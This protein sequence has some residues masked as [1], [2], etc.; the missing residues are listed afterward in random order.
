MRVQ[1][2]IGRWGER[3]VIE[4][5][6]SAMLAIIEMRRSTAEIGLLPWRLRQG[7]RN[8]NVGSWD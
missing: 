1:R 6:H 5:G 4:V 3:L 2:R 8:A 7:E